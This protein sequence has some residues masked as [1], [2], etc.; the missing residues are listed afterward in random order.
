MSSAF[1]P[2]SG[3]RSSPRRPAFRSTTLDETPELDLDVDGADEIG[4][5]L[6]LIK[7][8]GGALLREK[9]V[10]N[11]SRRMIVIADAGKRVAELGAFPLPI[12]VVAFGLTA[13]ARAIERAAVELGPDGADRR[14]GRSDGVPFVTDSG[15]RILDASFGRIPDP[16]ALASRLAGIPGVVE[17]G[18]F[19][20]LRRSRPRRVARRG[21]RD[22]GVIIIGMEYGRRRSRPTE[23]DM[24][25]SLAALVVAVAASLAAPGQCAGGA[26]GTATPCRSIMETEIPPERMALAMKLVQLSG[27]ARIFDEMLPTIAEQAKNAFIRANPQMQLGIIEVV[28]RI[29]VQL[30]SR[31]PE[32]DRYLARIWASGFSDEEMQELIDFYSTDTGKKFANALPQLLAVQT[33][34]AQ[35]WGKSVSE[36]LNAKVQAGAPRGHGGR[37]G[38]AA[39]RHRRAGR[40]GDA[41]RRSNSPMAYDY[42]LFVIGAGSGGVRA[43]RKAAETGARVA[44]AEADR[45]GGTCVIRGCMPKKLLVY[46][47]QFREEFEDSAAYGWSVGP[48]EFD[49]PTLIANKDKEIAR[50]EGV[51][52][53]NLA[54]AGAELIET[55]AVLAGRA[56]H[57]A[58]A[59][60]PHRHRRAHPDRD[61]RA[62]QSAR[63]ARG[64]RAL[65]HLQRGVSPA[66]GCRRRS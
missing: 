4:P 64:P 53:A 28:D 47:S 21:R 5:S 39:E 52:R 50:L 65:H 62:A 23:V 10:A 56:S 33:A 35:E 54:K 20:G 19:L 3:P 14:S 49:W 32:L 12:E 38:G 59:D 37:A 48:A 42:D 55:R 29:A 34:A 1:R 63:R 17:H 57:Q 16:E 45:V 43:A 6:A 51:Y 66:S 61:R 40:A 31:R 58:R 2:P 36:E 9:I 44:I 11:A 7:G 41:A 46:A 25:V 18:L 22:R 27:I 8:G 15:N 60:R 24:K 30:V 26:G 13:T